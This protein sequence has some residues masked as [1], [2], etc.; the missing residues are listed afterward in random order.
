VFAKFL[1]YFLSPPLCY[2][3]S[4]ELTV[5]SLCET[6][7]QT[8]QGVA[9]KDF[10]YT[11]TKSMTVYAF[12]AYQG[13]LRKLILKKRVQDVAVWKYLAHAVYHHAPIDFASYDLIIPVPLHT[14]RYA[15]RGYNQM[16]LFVQALQGYVPVSSFIFVRRIK[17]T[18]FQHGLSVEKR[19]E[20]LKD[21]FYIDEKYA[22]SLQGKKIL[23]IDDICTTG[24]TLQSLA[25]ACQKYKPA[26]I[27]AFVIARGI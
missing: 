20:N 6:C 8:V 27:D 2:G 1:S 26:K 11:S 18:Q 23:L 21:A 12:G 17:A 13:L 7:I 5:Y 22:L 9:P 16:E 14:Y 24:A 3:C 10:F 19:I 15:V 25:K 4:V